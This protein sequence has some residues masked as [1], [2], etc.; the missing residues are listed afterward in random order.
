MKAVTGS[1]NLGQKTNKK[2]CSNIS[3]LHILVSTDLNFTFA[4]LMIAY[5]DTLLKDNVFHLLSQKNNLRRKI[6][7]MTSDNSD[8]CL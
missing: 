8:K 4:I 2:V 6:Q 5:N 1:L 7:Q 3:D